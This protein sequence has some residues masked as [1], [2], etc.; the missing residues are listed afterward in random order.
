MDPVAG[1][2]LGNEH[3]MIEIGILI[4]SAGRSSSRVGKFAKLGLPQKVVARGGP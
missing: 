2:L 3:E 1:F 4:R